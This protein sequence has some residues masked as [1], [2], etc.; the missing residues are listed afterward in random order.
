MFN[1]WAK[2]KQKYNLLSFRARKNNYIDD[3]DGKCYT[4]ECII[5][6]HKRQSKQSL[7]FAF[8]NEEHLQKFFMG[9]YAEE[10]VS[11]RLAQ[12]KEREMYDY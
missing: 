11:W 4:G 3:Y 9:V 2:L 10:I 6:V 1:D 7:L 12:A 8:I 5:V